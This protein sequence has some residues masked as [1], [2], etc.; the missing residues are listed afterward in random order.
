MGQTPAT[1]RQIPDHAILD[2]FN[3]QHYLGNRYSFTQAFTASG[4]GEVAAIYLLNPAVTTTAFPNQVA[5][6]LDL[7]RLTGTVAADN[8]IL[9]TY[10][11]PTI[12][13]A[14][15][16]KTPLN[17]RPAS[18]NTSVATLASAPTASANGTLVEAL[19]S[20]AFG[21]FQ[22]TELIILDP[23]QGVLITYQASASSDVVVPMIAWSEI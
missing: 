9:R 4:T 16:A 7:R 2:H 15:T 23:G 11:N 19:A 8:Q 6:F 22:S 14:G 21:S 5:L 13:S 10:L 17:M 1:S 3:K 12:S 20:G 18:S